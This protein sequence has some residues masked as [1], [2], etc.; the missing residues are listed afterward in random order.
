[1]SKELTTLPTMTEEEAAIL[2]GMVSPDDAKHPQIPILKINYD[3]E[4]VHERGCWVVGQTKAKDGSFIDQGRVVKGLIIL[5]KR[6]RYSMYIQGDPMK[7]CSSPMYNG[8]EI[9]RG[10]THNYQC[11]KTCPFRATDAK[12]RCKSQFVVFGVAITTTGELVECQSYIQGDTFFPFKDYF[13]EI[14]S[15]VRVGK[16]TFPMPPFRVVTMLG[17]EKVKN[18]GATYWIG[19]FTPG[20][21]MDII[22]QGPWLEAKRDDFNKY[23][24]R[25]SGARMTDAA[26]PA[27]SPATPPVAASKPT[28]AM[29]EVVDVD[30]VPWDVAKTATMAGAGTTTKALEPAKTEVPVLAT[31]DD[32]FDVMAAVNSVLS[33]VKAGAVA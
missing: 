4:S 17:S 30:D 7:S 16:K 12:P 20:A 5:T 8:F 14:T 25:V 28:F 21:K 6:Q 13:D 15:P 19:R 31:D 32:D 9:V 33:S 29:P 11:G 18:P 24:E 27:A 26:S 10:G 2:A 23:I 3:P 1:M 22:K